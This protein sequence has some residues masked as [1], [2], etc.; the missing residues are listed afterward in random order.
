MRRKK[1]NRV[2]VHQPMSGVPDDTM[3]RQLGWYVGNCARSEVAPRVRGLL[4]ERLERLKNETTDVAVDE[5][6]YD[7]DFST[8]PPAAMARRA[9]RQLQ[10]VL[11][12]Y[13]E[14]PKS[15][16]P[17]ERNA[18]FARDEFGLDD[19]DV[20]ILLLVLRYE[21]N[22]SIEE[23]A[24]EIMMQLHNS[25]LALAALLGV[26]GREAGRRIAPDGTLASSGLLC[27]N[28]DA[29]STALAG[30]CGYLQM[31]APLRRVMHSHYRTRREWAAA[32]V[33]KPLATPLAWESYE[34]L[35]HARDLAAG[36]LAGAVDACAQGVNLLLHGPVGTGKT[37]LAKVLAART[38]MGIWSVGE[39]D[40][41][42][43]E[44]TR[45]ERLASL[46]L[47]QRLLTKRG[48]ALIL[49]D[50]AEDVLASPSSF[51]ASTRFQD[52][53]KVFLNR[54]LEQN[55]VPVV[56]TVNDTEFI[57]PAIL[58]RMT[59]ALEVKTPNQP[60]RARIW[61][62]VL[63]D[64]EV[65]LDADAVRRLSSRYE[66]PPG[67]V[68]NAVRAAA[69]AGGGEREIEQA[70]EGVLQTLGIGSKLLDADGGDFDPELANCRENLAD[71]VER[72]SRPG[73]PLQWSMCIHGAPGTGKSRFARHLAARLGM[74]VMQRRAS[75][76]LSKWVGDSE[77][78]IAAA[79]REARTERQLLVIDEADSLLSDRREAV[80]SW[81]VTQVNEML[82]W[83]ESHPLPFIC[84]TN[85]MDRLDQASLRR[86]TLKLRF[87]PLTAAQ[88]AL[89]FERFFGAPAPRPLPDG[90]SPGDFATVQRKRQLFGAP[91]AAVLADWL[92]EEARAKGARLASIGFAI[93]GG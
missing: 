3:R 68:T 75:D 36:V 57:D 21:R 19:T 52:G 53:S 22:A 83:M 49:V 2:P 16:E 39:A 62:Q 41:K 28:D 38:G 81:E 80:R 12:N 56:W 14:L 4:L 77:K 24:D 63:A 84:T 59:M 10:A 76:L 18:L 40:E 42:G 90:L 6:S 47:M 88:S 15:G 69:L 8:R 29:C 30:S 74:E 92:D 51:F 11:K 44:P 50:E 20:E 64:T 17:L 55:A 66:A 34:H 61:Q 46:T 93:G 86:F 82:T 1:P 37:E 31:T 48:R 65:T 85:L 9:M 5:W 67:V 71:L 79:F 73:G 26:S 25:A 72:L 27:L 32:L 58:R 23:L 43:G 78:A 91:S 45:G 13:R 33:G 60:V 35:G 70:L 54:L 87:D 7:E 89:A